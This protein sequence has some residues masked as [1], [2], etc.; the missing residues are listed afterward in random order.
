[1][2]DQIPDIFD[3]LTLRLCDGVGATMSRRLVEHFGGAGRALDADERALGD[4]PGIGASSARR[5]R[6]SVER[7]RENAE[8]ELEA[9]ERLGVRI[10]AHP[11]LIGGVAARA[12]APGASASPA[13]SRAHPAAYPPLLAE[14]DDA[15]ALLFVRGDDAAISCGVELGW[16]GVGIVGSRRATAYGIEQAERFAAHLSQHEGMSIVSGGAR[17]IDTAAHRATLRVGGRTAVV[18]GCGHAVAYPPENADLFE[19]VVDAG[20][21]VVSELPPTTPPMRENFPPRNRVISGLSLGVLIIEAPKRSGAL[22]TARLAVEEHGREALALPG[23]VDSPASSGSNAL[24]RAGA[25]G[26]ALTP[27]DVAEALDAPARHF[28]AGTHAARYP[29][30]PAGAMPDDPAPDARSAPAVP[31]RTGGLSDEQRLIIDALAEPGTPDAIV[32][33]TGLDASRVRAEATILEMR[34]LVR[35]TGG[36]LQRV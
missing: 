35:W 24:L 16:A 36:A 32:R 33:R 11:D 15:P 17:G 31:A 10:A 21:A 19:R 12:A 14:I 25:A 13:S 7:A 18:L 23:R 2:P 22:I 8:R 20:G 3:L 27:S 6:A 29:V 1:M 26:M 30:G 28:A 9:C 5:L 34:R 4:V